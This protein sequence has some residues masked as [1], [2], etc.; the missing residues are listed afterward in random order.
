MSTDSK[1]GANM[2][3]TSRAVA[4]KLDKREVQEKLISSEITALFVEITGPSYRRWEFSSLI[5][6]SE[7]PLGRQG[8][9]L[10]TWMMKC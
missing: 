1:A 7:I 4:R 9:K 2:S 10:V 6:T 8:C 5:K 3:L